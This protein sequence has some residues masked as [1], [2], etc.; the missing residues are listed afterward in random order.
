LP[1]ARLL[2]PDRPVL[3]RARPR[4]D[5]FIAHHERRLEATAELVAGGEHTAYEVAGGLRRTR[6]ERRL[7]ELDTFNKMLA[8]L[9]T[10][11][12]PD[13]LVELGQAEKGRS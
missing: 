2:P 11:A 12:R 4:V 7:K 5:E 10:K 6:R 13:L 3:E 8:V 1:E 9:E